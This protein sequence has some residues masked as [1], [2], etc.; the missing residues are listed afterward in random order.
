LTSQ[1]CLGKRQARTDAEHFEEEGIME[2]AKYSEYFRTLSTE[3][4]THLQDRVGALKLKD[5]VEIYSEMI[6]NP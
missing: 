1:K 6:V 5:M 4:I 2:W 3:E